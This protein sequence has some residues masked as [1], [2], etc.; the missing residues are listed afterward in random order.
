MEE[1]KDL[2]DYLSNQKTIYIADDEEPNCIS[3]DCCDNCEGMY[4]GPEYG[5]WKYKRTKIKK[6]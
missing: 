4:C 6:E 2:I 5:G 3:C 1:E